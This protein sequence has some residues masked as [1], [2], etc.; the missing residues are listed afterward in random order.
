MEQLKLQK[1]F[2][3]TTPQK[4]DY[5]IDCLKTICIF[6]V[7]FHNY[8]GE[9]SPTY[10]KIGACYWIAQPIPVFLIISGYLTAWSYAKKKKNTLRS[11][12]K[13]ND[14]LSQMLRFGIP[15]ILCFGIEQIISL[16][17]NGPTDAATFFYLFACGGQGMGTYYMAIMMQFIVL[18][19][20]INFLVKKYGFKAVVGCFLFTLS[21]DLMWWG[22][23]FNFTGIALKDWTDGIYK[24]IFCRFVFIV[25]CGTYL[26]YYKNNRYK[27]EFAI[28]SFLIGLTCL[29]LVFYVRIQ[30][31]VINKWFQMCEI[32]NLYI[33]PIISFLFRHVKMEKQ[34]WWKIIGRATFDIYL[35]QKVLYTYYAY[36]DKPIVVG[37]FFYQYCV[38][39]SII[40]SSGLLFWRLET[41]LTKLSRKLLDKVAFKLR[42]HH[43]NKNY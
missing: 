38:N 29:T 39:F 43:E 15:F 7:V 9:D 14:I 23:S 40:F 20:I 26:Y 25:S 33:F 22:I 11:C 13:M 21:W 2:N 42:A 30:F 36:P 5:F 31:H 12:Y 24:H 10:L 35:A 18:F 16:C 6:C 28:P 32:G 4:R 8:F 19:P 3:T 27:W 1:Q 37:N 34:W 41:P 17:V